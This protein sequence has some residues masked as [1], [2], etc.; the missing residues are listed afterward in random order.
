[1]EELIFL[2]CPLQHLNGPQNKN[3]KCLLSK[4]KI[5]KKCIYNLQLVITIINYI[6]NINNYT[7]KNVKIQK[8]EMVQGRFIA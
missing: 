6:F 3:E 4:L 2:K 8:K 5:Q 1:M 7:L